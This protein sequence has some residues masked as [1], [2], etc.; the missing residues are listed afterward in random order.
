[1]RPQRPHPRHRHQTVP[2]PA[3]GE[4]ALAYESLD[5][6]AEPDLTLTV[7]AAEPASPTAQALDHLAP[8]AAT[9]VDSDKSMQPQ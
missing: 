5:L 3:V 1:M 4:L 9:A 6:R 2:P 8:W 7:Y